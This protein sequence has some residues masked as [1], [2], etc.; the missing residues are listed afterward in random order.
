MVDK[1]I[2]LVDIPIII[3]G[4]IKNLNDILELVKLGVNAI[5]IA[6][7]LHFN[8]TT[9][10]DLKKELIKNNVDTRLALF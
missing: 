5:A 2:N 9:I 8:Q 10:S 7:I 1:I 3:S 6:N 4:G